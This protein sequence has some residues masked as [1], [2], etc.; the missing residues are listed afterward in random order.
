M[1]LQAP[2]RW[3]M[4]EPSLRPWLAAPAPADLKAVPAYMA[5]SGALR[6]PLPASL[7]QR[8]LTR[9][10]PP[11]PRSQRG[12]GGAKGRSHPPWLFSA[13]LQICASV[14]IPQRQAV[15][16][17]SP[18]GAERVHAPAGRAERSAEGPCNR[19]CA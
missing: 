11:P 1:P 19:P 4:R 13:A 17:G 2:P 8:R 16:P 12:H 5:A 6:L 10:P 15:G 7:S 18:E 14:S 9:P 3:P